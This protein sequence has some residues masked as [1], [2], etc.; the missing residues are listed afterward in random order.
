VK[1]SILLWTVIVTLMLL[2]SVSPIIAGSGRDKGAEEKIVFGNVQPGPDPWYQYSVKAFQYFAEKNGVE[3]VYLNSEY[4][5][6]KDIANVEDLIAKDVD[7]LCVFPMT[8]DLGQ[9][10]AQKANEAD[11]P[12]VFEAVTPSAGPA[13]YVTVVSFSYA[14]LGAQVAEYVHEKH[15]GAKL[16]YI[17]GKPGTGIIEQYV[18]GLEG[19]LEELSS[20]VEIVSQQPTDWNRQQAMEITQNLLQ[21]GQKIDV[22]FANNEDMAG[23]VIQVLKEAG[24]LGQIAVVS[25]GGSPEGVQ[26]I[27]AGELEATA[28]A[29]AGLEGALCFKAAWDAMHGKKIPKV[30]NPPLMMATKDNIDTAL[31]WEVNDTMIDIVENY[32][33]EF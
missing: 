13:E 30:I 16:V 12:F 1:R 22:I 21:S 31:T 17:T 23:G 26:L 6:D 29:S 8:A 14:K 11:I 28:A 15:P 5:Q 18:E 25:T 10:Y 2:V 27:K 24:K 3:V 33:Y 7:A 19:R 4:N 9:Q 20:D 32:K